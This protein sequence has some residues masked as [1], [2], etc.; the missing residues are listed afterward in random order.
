MN[1]KNQ[2]YLVN[3]GLKYFI[4]GGYIS[5]KYF[6]F[7]LLLIFFSENF[8]VKKLKGIL[9]T[10]KSYKTYK[11]LKMPDALANFYSL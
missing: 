3:K 4:M 7:N 10:L 2:D 6:N 5:E 11:L 8:L 1:G 9:V